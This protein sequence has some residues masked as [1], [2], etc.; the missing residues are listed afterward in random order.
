MATRNNTV[1]YA[2]AHINTATAEASVFTSGDITI[3]IPENTSRVFKSVVLEIVVHDNEATVADDIAAVNVGAS[4]NAGSNWTDRNV[5]TTQADSG[6]QMSYMLRADV[7]A[8]FTARFSGTSDTCRFRLQMDY[9][10]TGNQFLNIAAKVIISYEYDDSGQTTRLKTVRIPLDA[11]TARPTAGT[12]TSLGASCIPALDT[13]LPEASITYRAIFAEVWLNTAPSG[14]TDGTLTLDLNTTPTMTTGTIENGNQSPIL[15]RIIWDLLAAAMATNAAQ[16]LRFTPNT[17]AMGACVGG[18]VTVTYEYNYDTS[19]T[20]L[21]SVMLP[22]GN[23]AGGIIN[24]S[25]DKHTFEFKFNIEEPATITLVQSGVVIFASTNTTS[26]TFSLLV[27]GQSAR[28]YTVS[29]QTGQA[30]GVVIT[31]RIDSG[32]AQGAGVT[33][34]RGENTFVTSVYSSANVFSMVSGYYI[35]NYT[36]GVASGGAITHKRTIMKCIG[37]TQVTTNTIQTYTGVVDIP[38]STY[39]IDAVMSGLIFNRESSLGVAVDAELGSGEGPASGYAPIGQ[40]LVSTVGERQPLIVFFNSSR[41]YNRY[42]SD[43][44]ASRMDIETSRSYRIHLS[45]SSIAGLCIWITYHDI[46]VS[47]TRAVSGYAGDGSGIAVDIFR[48]DTDEKLY[49]VTTVAGGDYSVTLYD[50]VLTYYSVARED[51]TH[52][53][54]SNNWSP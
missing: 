24:A 39:W 48:E 6:E 31:Q 33:V 18:W 25:G 45:L 3:N 40:A 20:I 28:T 42:P 53:G 17:T 49:S 36:S 41:F 54:R 5:T 2:W 19:T 47:A 8:E 52:V 50:N 13:F 10:S 4:C 11:L 30:G 38:E 32:G 9:S 34:A 27:G 21:N 26:G 35:L 15:I 44:D 12:A 7:T 46:E 23:S 14:T 22:L 1:E 51:A 29:Q 43:P 16:T 37:D